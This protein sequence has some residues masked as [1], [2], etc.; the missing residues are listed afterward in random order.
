[1]T[2]FCVVGTVTAHAC[3]SLLNTDLL[4]QTCQHGCIASSVMDHLD[5]TDFQR[6]SINPEVHLT[7]LSTVIGP[8]F[9]RFPIAFTKQFDASV[10]LTGMLSLNNNCSA[11]VNA[12]LWKDQRPSA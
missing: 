8:M 2:A 4:E 3:D 7:P 9:L 6:G 5:S 10:R 11:L 12:K 1:M